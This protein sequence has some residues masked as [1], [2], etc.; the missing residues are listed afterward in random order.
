MA[1]GHALANP[2]CPRGN[3]H[4]NASFPVVK[5]AYHVQPYKALSQASSMAK[6]TVRFTFTYND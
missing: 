6:S 5:P 2:P 3:V 1:V 4:T